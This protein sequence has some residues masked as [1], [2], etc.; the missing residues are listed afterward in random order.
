MKT[1][2]SIF[3]LILC[4]C[5]TAVGQ[6]IPWIYQPTNEVHP[7]GNHYMEFQDYSGGMMSYYHDGID[8]M[9][10]YGQRPVF[11]CSD[12]VVTHISTGTMYGGIM[13]GDPVPG[14]EGWLYWHIPSSTMQF[15][16][17]DSV[18]TGDFIGRVATWSVYS[19]HHVHFN[20]VVGTGGY[21]WSWYESTDDPLD[22]LVPNDDDDPPFFHNAVP[23]QKF[24]FPQNN[25]SNYLSP[26]NLSGQID[27]IA[28][29]GDIVNDPEWPLNPYEIWYWINGPVSTN[30]VCSFIAA[31]WCPG[32]NTINVCYQ[33]DATCQTQGNYVVRD[34]YFN[35]TNTDGDSVIELSD[36]DYSWNTEFFPGGDY[37]IFVEAKD[38]FGNS[39][40]DSMMVTLTGTGADISISLTPLNPPVVIPA[41]GGSFDYTIEIT[42]NGTAGLTFAGWI[43]VTLP[44]GSFYGPVILASNIYLPAGGN[45]TRDRTQ[46]VP[47]NA[48]PGDYYFNGL[49]G[50][51]PGV[52][53]N[54][55]GFDFVK[56]E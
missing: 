31:G 20:Q 4:F 40:L 39:T 41:A 2:T 22:Y 54:E 29:I 14:G 55:H 21:P 36:T 38:Q 44:D 25:T 23:G 3:I 10:G 49:V 28:N 24:A 17:G 32:D 11:S 16:V 33:E 53:I 56:E 45:L 27:I 6:T 35:L 43:M 9:S 47:E 34:Y 52:I 50:D 19:F 13:I 18:Y 46:F 26:A 1:T 48:P 12:G 5:L 8:I 30:P 7:L 15:G 42:N 37:W 51:Y